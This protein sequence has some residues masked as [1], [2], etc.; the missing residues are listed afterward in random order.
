MKILGLDFETTGLEPE[1]D[2]VI[3][4][5]AV[6]WDTELRTPV[7]ILSELILPDPDGL[8]ELSQEVMDVTGLTKEL[9]NEYGRGFSQVLNYEFQ[10]MLSQAEFIVAH[11]APFDAAFLQKELIRVNK[12]WEDQFKHLKWIDTRTDL[13][14]HAYTKGKSASLGYMAADHGFINPFPHRAVT[15]VLTMLK[16]MDH[17]PMDAIVERAKSPTITVCA[18]VSFEEK[19]LA[20]TAGF[21]WEPKAKLWLMNVKE[22][23]LNVLADKWEFEVSQVVI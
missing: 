13:P 2:R 22:C 18:K 8:K 14:R 12:T 6:L 7:R 3:E 10:S 11:N 17:Y 16:L 9:I 5:G 19:D 20:K 15:D 4:L 21:H 1:Y 23:D